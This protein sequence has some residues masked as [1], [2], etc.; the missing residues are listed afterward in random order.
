MSKLPYKDDNERRIGEF[1]IE[2]NIL[3]S[4]QVLSILVNDPAFKDSW[5]KSAESDI[6]LSQFIDLSN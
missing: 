6:A 2:L 1:L 4:E 5:H 3:T